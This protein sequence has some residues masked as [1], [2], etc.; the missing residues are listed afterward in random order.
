MVGGLGKRDGE[1][2]LRRNW[3]FERGIVERALVIYLYDGRKCP[4]PGS[5]AMVYDVEET[6]A[7]QVLQHG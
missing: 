4:G 6:S 2:L 7:K 1:E 3:R 5:E